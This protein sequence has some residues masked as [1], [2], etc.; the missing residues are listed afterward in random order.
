VGGNER[1]LI[2]PLGYL[3]SLPSPFSNKGVTTPVMRLGGTRQSAVGHSSLAVSGFKKEWEFDYPI[4]SIQETNKLRALW[5]WTQPRPLRFIDP[6]ISNLLSAD[7]STGGGIS[8]TIA[9]FTRTGG[10]LARIDIVSPTLPLPI[11]SYLDSAIQWTVPTLTSGILLFDDFLT[12]YIPLRDLRPL[13][14]K[15]Q[16][17]GTGSVQA[18][19]RPR[20]LAGVVQ[21]DILGLSTVLDPALWKTLEVTY[22]PSAGHVS[23]V[24]GL[25]LSS[26]AGIRIPLVTAIKL[27]ELG[28]DWSIGEGIGSVLVSNFESR[29]L[30]L[31]N[32]D[33]RF[34]IQE[35]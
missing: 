24:A 26:T 16:V 14:L 4:L 8:R 12:K 28:D 35:V 10:D 15:M 21:A 17:N 29:Y 33:I 13:T 30:S 34:S 27:S 6:F 9:A 19:I 20:N 3:Q 7:V 1:F 11:A 32:Y 5:H 31:H 22:T 18:L 23:C 25:A 2:G